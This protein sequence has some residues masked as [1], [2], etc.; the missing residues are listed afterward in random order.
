MNA[1]RAATMME[2]R[3]VI[4]LAL[5]TLLIGPVVDLTQS[6]T[7]SSVARAKTANV[8]TKNAR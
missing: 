8:K 6:Y 5:W 7:S 4:L 3:W 2:F 1:T